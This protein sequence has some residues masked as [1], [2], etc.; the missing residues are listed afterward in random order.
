M[1]PVTFSNLLKTEIDAHI[2]LHNYKFEYK[3]YNEKTRSQFDDKSE[4]I[5]LKISAEDAIRVYFY[6]VPTVIGEVILEFQGV[7]KGHKESI[8]EKLKIKSEGILQFKNKA[9]LINFQSFKEE[10]FSVKVI[11]P[12]FIVPDSEVML[13]LY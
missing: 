13:N 1:I 5:S 12:A 9:S 4:T 7:S 8:Q 3:F 6:I 11:I 10:D 2:T